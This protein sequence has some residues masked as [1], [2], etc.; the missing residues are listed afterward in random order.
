MKPLATELLLLM[1]NSKIEQEVKKMTKSQCYNEISRNRQLINQY[2]NEINTL[3]REIRELNDTK[4]KVSTLKSTLSSCKN[5]SVNRL[6]STSMVMRINSK[7]V[8]KFCNNMNTLFAGAEYNSVNNG[9]ANGLT[10]IEEEITR[11]QNRIR[12]LG[13]SIDNCNNTI[14]N[15]NATIRRIEA[16]EREE[17]RRRA[18]ERRRAESASN[19]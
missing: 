8:N 3:N 10:R 18:E 12:T 14:S 5:T 19:G 1:V 16:Q 6:S 11:K 2:Q 9:L 15:M 7:I 4:S 13:N 17:A